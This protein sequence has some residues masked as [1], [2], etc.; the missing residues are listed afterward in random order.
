M[1]CRRSVPVGATS[2]SPC[3]RRSRHSRCSPGRGRLASTSWSSG[4]KPSPSPR[5]RP[6]APPRSLPANS[7]PPHHRTRSIGAAGLSD[8]PPPKQPPPRKHPRC[9]RSPLKASL[10]ANHD[11]KLL[12]V[13]GSWAF[14]AG[15]IPRSHRLPSPRA[16]LA[17]LGH[18]DQI[19]PYANNHHR[20]SNT[21]QLPIATFGLGLAT[22]PGSREEPS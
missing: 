17:A 4:F 9:S 6:P 3:G 18:H 8:Q 19:I 10:D 1:A 22:R 15:H 21:S 12:M 11:S 20:R 5:E 14:R 2:K 13:V 7:P 16:A